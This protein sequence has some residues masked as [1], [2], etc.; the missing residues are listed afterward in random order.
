MSNVD[1]RIEES[2][3]SLLREEWGKLYFSEIRAKVK[4]SKANGANVYPK[5]SLI[6]NA[7][8]STPVDRVKVVVLGQDPYHRPRQAMGLSFSVP[9]GV[10]V[11]PSLVNIYKELHR[12][13]GVDIPDHGDLQPWA[14][15]GVFLLNTSLTVEEGKAGSHAR[16]GWQDFTDAV[17]ARLSEH[18]EYIVFML[19]GN[20]AKKKAELIDGG[21]H[22]ILQ[23]AH[24]SPLAGNRYV[25]S[26]H[27]SQA[28][29]Y[30]KSHGKEPINWQL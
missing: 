3:K 17:I 29:D 16:I 24:P 6:F 10:R 23:A 26:A 18:R 9:K 5:G 21:K 20:H 25:G 30:L 7:F 13:V 4:E 2:W 1:V 14:D 12:D 19:W 27:F 15:Q 22:L 11:P 8:D 28:N